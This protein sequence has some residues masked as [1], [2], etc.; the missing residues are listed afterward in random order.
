MENIQTQKRRLTILDT[1][2]GFAV[3]IMVIFHLEYDL[4]F[5][6]GAPWLSQAFFW[7]MEY[8]SYATA[9]FVILA[10]ITVRFSH[11]PAKHGARILIIATAFTLVTSFVFPGAAIYFGVLH[12]IASGMFVYSLAQKFINRIPWWAGLLVCAVLFAFTFHVPDGYFGFEW[13]RLDL[14]R[15][16]TQGNLLYPF[17]FIS[18]TFNSVDYLPIF[19]WLFMYLCG[20]F[21]GRPI[22]E[23]VMPEFAYRDY[24]KP[25]TWMGKHSLTIYIVHQPVIYV[26]LYVIYNFILKK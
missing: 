15:S 26:I 4:V 23:R 5:M 10:G 7:Q 14:P 25:L 20:T 13:L 17:G 24:C 11:N 9:L 18:R 12:L 6:F 8:S 22:T 1:L 16:L 21:V 2:R 19:P 3:V